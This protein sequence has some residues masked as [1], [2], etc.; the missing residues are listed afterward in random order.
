VECQPVTGFNVTENWH[1]AEL[2]EFPYVDIKYN[3][4]LIKKTN[5][6]PRVKILQPG[7]GVGGHC[8]AVDP[9]FI[10]D[11]APKEARLMRTAREVNDGKPAW[12]I[13]K[14]REAAT[15][16]KNPSV[17]CLGLAFKANID[18]LR[19]SPA[20]EIDAHLADEGFKVLAVEPHVRE[21]PKALKGKAELTGLED[22]LG[23]AG[24]LLLLVD[25]SVFKAI[26][27]A[28]LTGKCVIDTRGV[29][30]S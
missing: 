16:L 26:P 20:V 7:P 5:R 6:H 10:V 23:R 4:E 21:L 2:R 1:W 9:W 13:G 29:W 18:D 28:L 12:V 27:P 22:A 11:S 19:E 30:T 24:I 25:H 3:W 15:G 17:A 14:V 8:I